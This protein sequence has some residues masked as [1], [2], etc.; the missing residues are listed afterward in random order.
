MHLVLHSSSSI[1]RDR[2]P[3]RAWRCGDI[4]H[5]Q[6]DGHI[7]SRLHSVRN[8]HVDLHQTGGLS[9]RTVGV[10]YCRL[11][12]AYRNGH[13]Q[14]RARRH[15][16]GGNCGLAFAGRVERDVPADPYG[17][18]AELTDPSMT[19]TAAARPAPIWFEV[20]MPGAEAAPGTTNA[21]EVSPW[22]TTVTSAVVPV[23]A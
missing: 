19:L 5:L 9:G 12:S 2:D 14:Y 20:K 4:S 13:R 10:L 21:A 8:L 16:S 22:E 1:P 11:H 15:A 7:A 3:H 18:T 6:H 17:L 23:S